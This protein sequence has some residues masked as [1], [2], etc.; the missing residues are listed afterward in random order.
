LTAKYYI[1][2]RAETN[3]KLWQGPF[4]TTKLKEL[5]DR[6]LFSKELHEFSEDRLNWI[7]ARQIWPTLFPRKAM[8]TSKPVPAPATEATPDAE[9]KLAP[10]DS[11]QSPQTAALPTVDESPD[12]YCSTDGA[13]QGPFTL[14]QL[15][16]FVTEGRVQP[17]DLVW[18]PQFGEQWV[19]AQSV[20]ELLP[21]AGSGGGPLFQDSGS[22]NLGKPHPLALASL[23][24]S[25]LGGTCLLGLGSILAIVFGHMAL[26]QITRSQ[27]Q[28]PGKWMAITGLCL[29]YAMVALLFIVLVIYLAVT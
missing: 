20:P 7:S 26:S 12:W 14:S 8:A 15:R 9:I 27:P 28:T 6:R 5:A 10:A 16:S 4:D 11:G 3:S 19:E 24:C 29:G 17:I 13:Q 18:C 22:R 25:L 23:I 1:R 21:T 2:P